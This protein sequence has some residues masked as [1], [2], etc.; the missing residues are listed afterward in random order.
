MQDWN[1]LPFGSIAFL[2]TAVS[3]LA[4]YATKIA[5]WIPSLR[6]P[7]ETWVNLQVQVAVIFAAAAVASVGLIADRQHHR[8]VLPS[9]MGIL[10]VALIAW[11]M[12]APFDRIEDIIGLIVLIAAVF[13]NQ[14]LALRQLTRTLRSRQEHITMQ[15]ALLEQQTQE[16]NQWNRMLS[17]RVEEQLAQIESLGRPK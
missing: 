17:Q 5:V 3:L 7:I 9:I 13:F 8:N 4:C 10:G 1:R 16:L 14:T 2:G 12:D 11:S 15:N 6:E